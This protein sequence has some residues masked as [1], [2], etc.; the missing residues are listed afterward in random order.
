MVEEESS[1]GR[2]VAVPE[3]GLPEPQQDLEYTNQTAAK[4]TAPVATG[5]VEVRPTKASDE[6]VNH[7][8]I[9]AEAC[10]FTVVKSVDESVVGYDGSKGKTTLTIT[11][12]KER[13]NQL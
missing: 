4:E 5:K 9:Q 8:T 1:V 2:G 3:V 11:A 10:G 13:K 6:Q 12:P 7:I